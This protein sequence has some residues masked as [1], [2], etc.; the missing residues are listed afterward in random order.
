MLGHLW[1][2]VDRERRLTGHRVQGEGGAQRLEKGGHR[3]HHLGPPRVERAKHGIGKLTHKRG[4]A[5]GLIQVDVVARGVLIVVPEHVEG[6]V[7]ESCL[8]HASWAHECDIAAIAQCRGQPLGLFG[9]VAK[10]GGRD[11]AREQERIGRLLDHLVCGFFVCVACCEKFVAK[12][13]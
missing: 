11:V 2:H 6:V 5:V 9:P 13:S 3:L 12:S 10:V 4:K 8:A 1:L 7:Y